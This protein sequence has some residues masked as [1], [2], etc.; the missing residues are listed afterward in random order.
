MGLDDDE[1]NTTLS[2]MTVRDQLANQLWKGLFWLALI[3]PAAS[4]LRILMAG[5]RWTYGAHLGLALLVILVALNRRRLNVKLKIE[6]AIAVPFCIGLAGLLTFGFYGP[7]VA[8]IASSCVAAAMFCRKGVVLA[9]IGMEMS[10]ILIAAL[11]FSQG[12]LVLHV[13]GN[14]FIAHFYNWLPVFFGT[15]VAVVSIAFG[16]ATY[17]ESIRSLMRAIEMQHNEIARQRDLIVHQAT[18]DALTGLPTLRLARDRL[19]MACSQARREQTIAAV[20]FMDLDGFKAANDSFGHEAGDH[21][22]KIVADRLTASIRSCDTVARLGGDEFVVIMQ[23]A[24]TRDDTRGVAVKLLKAIA[25][26]IA[27]D[28]QVINIGA[29]IGIAIFPDHGTSAELVLK[30]ADQAMYVVKR[31]GKNNVGFY[32]DDAHLSDYAGAGI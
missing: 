20:L 2:E 16:I 23:K 8:W 26:P 27:Y 11:G 5:W 17:N 32:T 1:L 10:T 19:E 24:G 12:F 25:E 21:V 4:A 22:L 3:A 13:D 30:R 31:S 7:A 18:H 14:D 29:S 9:I 15:S 6:L 28:D